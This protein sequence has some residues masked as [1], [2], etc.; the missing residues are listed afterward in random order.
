[1]TDG[2]GSPLWSLPSSTARFDD[3]GFMKLVLRE[4]E[5]EEVGAV[6]KALADLVN[7]EERDHDMSPTMRVDFLYHALQL[8]RQQCF[9]SLKASECL[10]L[11]D[12]TRQ[13]LV[14]SGS[15]PEAIS[16][17][18]KKLLEL[19]TTRSVQ[20]KHTK[21]VQEE[22]EEEVV[23]EQ[24]VD[25]KAK[26]GKGKDEPPQTKLVKRMVTR[27]VAEVRMFDCAP[28]FSYDDCTAIIDHAA[29][30][31]FQH[32]KLYMHVYTRSRAMEHRSVRLFIND[33]M[34]VDPLTT[35]MTELQYTA[36]NENKAHIEAEQQQR[37][38]VTDEWSADLD[39]LHAEWTEELQE[40]E[41][42]AQEWKA[43]DEAKALSPG[44]FTHT[45]K[46][47]AYTITKKEDPE[48]EDEEDLLLRRLERIEAALRA[49]E[50]PETGKGKKK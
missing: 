21:V 42:H 31:L 8:C 17:F 22:I 49:P 34:P 46:C 48:V 12:N 36:F 24:V 6:R 23:V 44:E 19:T 38:A 9:S 18:K 1:M 47:L 5:K 29:Q 41:E 20:A 2:A 15:L 45:I 4:N 13:H 43:E 3:D 33:C 7:V 50:V 14:D 26:K 39:T 37:A 30:T 35:A 11:L 28:V 40:M 25:P 16:T 27:E 10:Q 32:S